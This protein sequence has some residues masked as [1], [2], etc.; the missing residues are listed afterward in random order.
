[1]EQDLHSICYFIQHHS[2]Q[3]HHSDLYPHSY[4]VLPFIHHQNIHRIHQNNSYHHHYLIYLVSRSTHLGTRSLYHTLFNI[5]HFNDII[6]SIST[7]IQY[8]YPFITKTFNIIHFND[9]IHSISILIQY[10]S[11]HSIH[12]QNI[13]RI[14]LNNSYHH[15]YIIYLVSRSTHLGTRSPLYLLLYSTSF[16]SMTSFTLYSHSYSIIPSIHQQNIHRIHLNNSYHHHYLIYL[17]S[18]STHWNKISTLFL[19][20]YFIQHHS[21]HDIIRTLYSHTSPF[22]HTV[23][24]DH[25]YFHLFI[26]HFKTFTAFTRITHQNNHHHYLIYL[27]SRST[28][29]GTRSPLY[30]ILYSTSFI[31]MTSFTL[32][33]YS[34]SIIPSIH[35]QNIHRIHLNNSYHHHYIIYLVSRSTHLGTRSPLYFLLYSTSFISMTSFTLYSHSHSV[36]SS[37]YH[38]NIHRIHLNNSYHHHYLIYLVSRSTNLGTRSPLYFLLYSTSF[39]SM[40]S[41]PLYP[42]SYSVIPFIHHQN[43]HRIHLNN[44]YHHHYLIYLVSR[45]THLG[46]RSPL[47]IIL[48]STSFISMTSFTLY[49]YSYRVSFHHRNI[50]RIH[51]NNSYHHHIHLS[52]FKIYT[53]WN[54]PLYTSFNIIH[55]NDII[56]SISTLT[57]CHS[58]HSSK[59]SP[60]S[61][62]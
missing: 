52:C 22:T 47:Y 53:S 62:E 27:V 57:Q 56:H 17:V 31:S 45:S 41:F 59:H 6:P 44:S 18:R 1:M 43:I 51:L 24:Q 20:Y 30:I 42:H 36:I 21:F 58:I 40:T 4:S 5:I 32:Y 54:I 38:Q 50:H 9:I 35:H 37:I 13:H 39:I 14:H 25:S 3:W 8:H 29:L 34:Y 2:F 60:H 7:L 55:F 19:L 26:I 48:Y 28:H 10:H 16:I 49:P 33:P 46:T 61:P 23:E 15:H 11:I 12:H